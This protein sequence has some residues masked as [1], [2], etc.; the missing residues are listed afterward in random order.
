MKTGLLLVSHSE[1]LARGTRELVSAMAREV[2]ILITAGDGNGGLGTRAK[3]IEQAV[4]SSDLE[5]V[6]LLFDLGS[7]LMNAEMAAEMLTA[8]GYGMTVVD[9]PFVE[10]ALAAGMAL[11]VG[12]SPSEAAAEAEATRNS[13]KKG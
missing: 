4:L 13:P 2:P 6:I 5:N 9:A 10:G 7:A 1:A 8:Q 12:K 3:A 11:Q